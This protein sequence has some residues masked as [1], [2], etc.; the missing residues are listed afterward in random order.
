MWWLRHHITFHSPDLQALMLN[1]LGRFL[2]LPSLRI[3]L[4][5]ADN[6]NEKGSKMLSLRFFV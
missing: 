1:L 3:G 5:L 4:S 6:A 2:N